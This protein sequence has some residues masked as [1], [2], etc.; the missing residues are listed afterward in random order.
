MGSPR[1]AKFKHIYPTLPSRRFIKLMNN[2]KFSRA[3]AKKIFQLRSGHVPLNAYLHRFKRK[4][5][6]QCPTC[7]ALKEIAQ[8]FLLECPA[9]AYE[10]WK[11]R[12]RKG[13]LETKFA[14]T[15]TSENK[16]IM[17]AHYIHANGRFSEESQDRATEGTETHSK[18]R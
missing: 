7:G 4:D 13:E 6:A 5:S 17:L 1:Y 11:L 18:T 2:P 14:E 16:S 9:Y 3:D 8:H 15:L 12:P 10:R